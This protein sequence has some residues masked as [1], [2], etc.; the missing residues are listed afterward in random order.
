MKLR[1]ASSGVVIELTGDAG[2]LADAFDMVLTRAEDIGEL[3]GV[4]DS[5]AEDDGDG[6]VGNTQGGPDDDDP[7]GTAVDRLLSEAGI[8]SG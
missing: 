8:A 5:V 2:G 4:L 6:G 3:L 1:I 7:G